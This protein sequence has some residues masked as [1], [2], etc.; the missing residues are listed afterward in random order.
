[1][2]VFDLL[3]ELFRNNERI[4]QPHTYM[5]SYSGLILFRKI[6][7]SKFPDNWVYIFNIE[8]WSYSLKIRVNLGC[9]FNVL[10]LSR[11]YLLGNEPF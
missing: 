9:L 3:N 7:K 8:I 1:M 4:K 6:T 11:L 2:V 5:V 10:T